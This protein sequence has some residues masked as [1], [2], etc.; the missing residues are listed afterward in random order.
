MYFY[1]STLDILHTCHVLF[2][3]AVII[4]KIGYRKYYIEKIEHIR[5][6]MLYQENR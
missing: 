3:C 2:I 4:N 5:S 6:A 1:M